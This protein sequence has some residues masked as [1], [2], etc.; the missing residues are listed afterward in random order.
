MS[1]AKV[2]GMETKGNAPAKAGELANI[3]PIEIEV[4]KI[5]LTV[6]EVRQ[7]IAPTA[8][9]TEL[10]WFMGKCRTYGLNPLKDEIYFIK[11]GTEPGKA[12]INYLTYVKR[13]LRTGLLTGW[14]VK[15]DKD[16]FGEKAVL[17]IYRRDWDEPFVWETYRHEFDQK[18]ATWKAMP[19]HMLRVRVIGQGFRIC[20]AD[21]LIGMPYTEGETHLQAQTT[22]VLPEITE[23]VVTGAEVID[24]DADRDYLRGQYFKLANQYFSSPDT[25]HTW[26]EM[27]HKDG[28]ISSDSA[29]TMTGE[30]FVK[31][32]DMVE[33]YI[34]DGTAGE[35]AP[36][37][38]AITEAEVE[39]GMESA[40]EVQANIDE[41][42][43]KQE[44]V[45]EL[46]K[47]SP[48][49]SVDTPGFNTWWKNL[50]PEENGKMFI[51]LDVLA[52][53]VIIAAIE[54]RDDAEADEA[55]DN[56]DLF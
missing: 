35:D 48:L 21:E 18:R 43:L 30:D 22:E 6:E 51:E 42:K 3:E 56:G 37:Q 19:L 1:E 17:T 4:E 38:P 16:D 41:L 49:E 26:Q 53:D 31:V 7:H 2:T 54:E 40:D 11:Y 10:F 12:V 27:M 8:T 46:V 50:M 5:V 25:R 47:D 29:E 45:I 23:A 55:S 34:Q 32:R 15:L 52:L 33:A 28:T 36:E 20:F 39:V 44:R 14:N 24:T 13:A 9:T